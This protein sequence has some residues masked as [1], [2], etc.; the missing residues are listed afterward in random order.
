MQSPDFVA[1]PFGVDFTVEDIEKRLAAG[2]SV[3]SV[4]ARPPSGPRGP[5]TVP[6]L[7]H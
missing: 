4:L 6:L 3:R 5:E 1:N 2:E 7:A